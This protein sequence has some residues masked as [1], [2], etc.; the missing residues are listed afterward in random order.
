LG[1]A[2]LLHPAMLFLRN[3]TASDV[4]AVTPALLSGTLVSPRL[5]RNRRRAMIDPT[6]LAVV[7]RRRWQNMSPR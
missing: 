4:P 2:L 3:N 5:R 1:T 7:H 6:A